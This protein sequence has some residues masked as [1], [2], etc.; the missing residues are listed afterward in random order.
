MCDR[1][2][3][4]SWAQ[5]CAVDSAS[6]S[7]MILVWIMLAD[8]LFVAYARNKRAVLEDSTFTIS[9]GKCCPPSQFYQPDIHIWQCYFS[10]S[11]MMCVVVHMCDEQRQVFVFLLVSNLSHP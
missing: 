7:A 5:N 11:K 6:I 9:S 1:A 4:T 3:W 2:A 8:L 10:D